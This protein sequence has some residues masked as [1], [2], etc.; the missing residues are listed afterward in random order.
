MNINNKPFLKNNFQY[1]VNVF[2]KSNV[3][4]QPKVGSRFFLF[5]SNWPKNINEVY[6]QYQ[7]DLNYSYK[8]NNELQLN[9]LFNTFDATITFIKEHEN[10]CNNYNDFFSKNNVNNINEF[11]LEN[12]KDMYFVIR[13]P[14]KRFLSGLSQV[15]SAYVS[16]YITQPDERARIK[17]FSNI[18]DLEIDNIYNNYNDYFNEYDEFS[19]SVLSKINIDIFVKIIVYILNHKSELY[20]YDAHTQN[21]LNKYK[22]LIYNIKDKSKVKII[23]LED[24]SKKSAYDLFNTWSD[25][26]DYTNAYY[27]TT[28]HHVSNKKLYNYIDFILTDVTN[29][30]HSPYNF[31]SDEINQYNELK[32]S[33]YFIKL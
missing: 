21:Y 23:D 13:N 15:A 3:I 9:T 5:L 7:I 8:N 20:Y 4:C 30:Y 31:L 6:N 18:T 26:I 29:V 14:V 27:N 10:S 25:N 32:N 17:M 11:F 33:K 12:S 16:D 24:C 19:E 2:D 22:E 1:I 28:G